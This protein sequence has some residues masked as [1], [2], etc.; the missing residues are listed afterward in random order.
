M[1]AREKYELTPVRIA[2]WI[3]TTVLFSI[4]IY[5]WFFVGVSPR[6]R[7]SDKAYCIMNQRNLQQ[8]VRSYANMEGLK[9]GDPLEWS[10]IIGPGHFLETKPACPVHGDHVL[11]PVLPEPSTLAAPCQDPEHRPADTEDW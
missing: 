8:A 3:I 10:K 11:S 2:F 4:G 9:P 1:L 6:P 5:G 7:N